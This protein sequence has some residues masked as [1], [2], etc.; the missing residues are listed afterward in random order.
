MW[1]IVIAVISSQALIEFVKWL[2]ERRDKKEENPILKLLKDIEERVNEVDKSMCKNF[3]VRCLADFEKG[4]PLSDVER[5]RFWEQYQHYTQ[6]LKGNT[7][8]ME[9]T[10]RLKKDGKIWE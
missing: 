1:E 8:I 2:I 6:D 10:E 4:N 7:Y 9:W 3:L 5:E